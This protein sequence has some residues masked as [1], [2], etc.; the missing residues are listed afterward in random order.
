[1]ELKILEDKQKPLLARRELLVEVSF[2]NKT[3]SRLE[4]RKK[5]AENLKISEE[6]IIIKNI[7]TQFGYR[8]ANVIAH[9]YQNKKDLESV[10]P[11][12]I[13]KRHLSKE[14]KKVEAKP[15]EKEKAEG[16][17]VE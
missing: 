7:E 11:K 14:E 10:E 8:K 16:K 4:M 13:K 2:D 3:P 15:A 17:K 5:L 6:I 9:V 12:H 1:M